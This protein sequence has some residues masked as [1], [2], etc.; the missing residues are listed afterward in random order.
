[1]LLAG[2][3]TVQTQ[4][5][6]TTGVTYPPT[7][8]ANVQILS[9]VPTQPYVRLGQVQAQPSS[10][11]LPKAR[12]EAAI[13]T[14]AAQMG[15]DAVVIVKDKNREV[16]AFPTGPWYDQSMDTLDEKIIIGEAIKYTSGAGQTVT[17]GTVQMGTP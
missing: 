5:S 4:V 1:M 17:T 15:A 11:N 3:Q 14:A 6:A 13:Q 2:C 8:P 9:T 12:I 10:G 16:G 7:N